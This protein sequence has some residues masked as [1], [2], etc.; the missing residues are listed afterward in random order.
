MEPEDTLADLHI[1][2]TSSDGTDSL[3]TRLEQAEDRGLST[4][5]VTDHDTISLDLT[6]R[7]TEVDGI[8]LI[9]GVEVRAD[10]FDTKVELLGYYVD[11]SSPRLDAVLEQARSYRHDRNREILDRLEEV[12]DESYS[13]TDLSEQTDGL[14]GRPDI[15]AELVD[16]GIVDSI[17]A[18][19][20]EHL[21]AD[22]DA[23]VPMERVPAG[24]VIDAIQAANGVVSLA[25]PGRI[26]S[27]RVPEMV[28]GLTDLGL[29]GIEVWYPYGSSGPDAYADIEVD[30]ADAL[31]SDHGLVRTGG[32]DCHGS[33]SEKFRIGSVG[34]PPE[35]LER[36]RDTAVDRAPF[37]A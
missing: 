17:G 18:A 14:L 12:T 25:H 20:D 35:S 4:I 22:G 31:A 32:S 37:E 29:D 23:F 19:F 15:A 13:Y 3:S 1:H 9:S 21:G 28:S 27:D 7:S 34:V 16:Q 8:E 2:T 5:A 10:L 11:P 36:L 6:D 30:G 26:R 33:T 24:E